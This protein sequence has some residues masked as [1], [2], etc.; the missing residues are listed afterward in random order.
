MF[1]KGISLNPD[2]AELYVGKAWI[3]F[4]EYNYSDCIEYCNKMLEKFPRNA[5]LI[6]YKADSYFA[7]QDFPM[8]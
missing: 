4:E 5:D 6:W 2:Y 3:K 7:K 8:L 1:N